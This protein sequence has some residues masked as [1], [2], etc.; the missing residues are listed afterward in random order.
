MN[1]E[2]ADPDALGAVAVELTAAASRIGQMQTALRSLLYEL[3]WSGHSA[4]TLRHQ[5]DSEVAPQLH[6]MGQGLDEFAAILGREANQQSAASEAEGSSALLTGVVVGGTSA[7][8]LVDRL[9][10]DEQFLGDALD[11]PGETAQYVKGVISDGEKT[12]KEAES[13]G[14]RMMRDADP[15]ARSDGATLMNDGKALARD[16]DSLAKEFH[17]SWLEGAGRVAAV[18]GVVLSVADGV[19]EGWK[20]F[21]HDQSD[22]NNVRIIKASIVGAGDAGGSIAGGALGAMA[23][24]A[25][26]PVLGPF[27]T[28]GGAMVGAWIGGWAGKEGGE[29]VAGHYAQLA[30]I[31]SKGIEAADEFGSDVASGAGSAWHDATSWA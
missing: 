22:P 21:D 29:L 15:V 10:H 17:G 8:S 30:H 2:G 4:D 16:T 12:A 26:D 5:W 23:G 3:Q 24:S 13:R 27:G 11:I 6:A 31:G 19:F 25:L 1:M 7:T 9:E 20:Y 14:G 18:G 28:I